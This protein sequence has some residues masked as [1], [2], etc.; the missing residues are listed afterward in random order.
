MRID[1][2]MKI[3]EVIQTYPETVSVFT[4][5]GVACVGCSAASYD[6]IE[7]GAKIHGIDIDQFVA[8]LNASIVSRN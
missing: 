2:K 7:V 3:E 4:R 8:D 1:K 5:Y 6:N